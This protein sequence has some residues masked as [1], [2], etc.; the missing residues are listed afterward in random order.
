MARTKRNLNESRPDSPTSAE[1]S[2]GERSPNAEPPRG[3]QGK[4]LQEQVDAQ[5]KGEMNL[6][7]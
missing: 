5:M 2:S 1:E 3:R 7:S 6:R 4:P